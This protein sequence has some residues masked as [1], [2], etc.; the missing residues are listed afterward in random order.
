MVSIQ[1]LWEVHVLKIVFKYTKFG[2]LKFISHLDTMRVLQ[3]AIRRTGTPVK[4]S[5]GF[6]P[7]QKLSIAFPLSL[8]IESYG[9]YAEI[10]VTNDIDIE[11]FVVKINKVLPEGL[12]IIMAGEYLNSKTLSSL[13]DSQEYRIDLKLIDE[14]SFQGCLN[15][16][17]SLLENDYNIV[18]TRIKKNKKTIKKINLIEYIKKIEL[19][20]SEGLDV[21]ILMTIDVTENGSIKVEEIKEFIYNK[22][23]E[24]NSLKIIRTNLNFIDKIM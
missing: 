7:H 19:L 2:R 23:K 1:A 16:F 21:S 4:Y 9:E 17:N 13:I 18:R 3:R 11:E 6:N 10:E 15:I 12:E 5:E 14:D 24:I 20:N 8:G 22:F